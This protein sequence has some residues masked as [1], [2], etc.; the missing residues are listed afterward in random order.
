MSLITAV[1][2]VA[3]DVKVAFD[4]AKENTLDFVED[5]GEAIGSASKE[6][7]T[8]I[9]SVSDFNHFENPYCASELHAEKMEIKFKD[10]GLILDLGWFL[11]IYYVGFFIHSRHPDEKLIG[12]FIKRTDTS[13]EVWEKEDDARIWN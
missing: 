7:V 2:P 9:K 13:F 5:S 1:S 12:D 10:K 8:N 6:A 11:K 4:N 3:L